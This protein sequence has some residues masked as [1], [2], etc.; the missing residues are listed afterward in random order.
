MASIAEKRPVEVDFLAFRRDQSYPAFS[1]CSLNDDPGDGRPESGA[2]HGQINGYLLWDT[3]D[4]V[5]TPARWEVTLKLTPRAP[6]DECMVDV[7]PRRLQSLKAVKGQR[8][9]WSIQGGVKDDV[10]ADRW[11]LITVPSVRVTKLG[12]RLRV[13]KLPEAPEREKNRS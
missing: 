5:D 1:R 3:N 8:F 9:R 2:P 13:E 10:A 6:R 4:I 7:T 11:G 12:T